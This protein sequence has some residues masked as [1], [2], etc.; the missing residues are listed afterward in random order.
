MP[1]ATD[2]AAEA[3]GTSPTRRWASKSRTIS[4]DEQAGEKS[5]PFFK[6]E[7]SFRRKSATPEESSADAIGE[8]ES[9]L[10]EEPV[11]LSAGATSTCRAAPTR[12]SR[13]SVA[14]LVESIADEALIVEDEQAEEKSVPFFKREISFRR[15]SATPEE[16]SVDAIGEDESP[17]IEEPV[18]LSAGV[19]LDL[20]SSADASETDDSAAEPVESIA[21]EALVVEDEQAEEKSVPFYKREISF[22]RKSATP[23]ESVCDAIGEDE[24]PVGECLS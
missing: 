8:D 24:S 19:D 10:I 23:E 16:S 13:Y 4:E 1:D 14:D 7:I 11:E 18:E 6:R 15:K 3:S 22:R 2:A 5:V 12:A 21:D 17:L 9:P 20:S